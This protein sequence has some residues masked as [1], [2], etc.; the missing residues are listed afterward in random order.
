MPLL[1]ATYALYD[2]HAALTRAL[3]EDVALRFARAPTG[4]GRLHRRVRCGAQ[5]GALLT[6]HE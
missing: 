3:L 6:V 2:R 1:T 4:D 5:P